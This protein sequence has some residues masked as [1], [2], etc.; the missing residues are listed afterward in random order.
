M[1]QVENEVGMLEDA[2]DWSPAANKMFEQPVPG[3]LL[4]YLSVHKNRLASG[5]Y[6]RWKDNDFKTAG[7]W[8]AVFGKGLATDEIF[9]AWH[10]ADYINDV[11]V[12]GK[13]EYPLPMFVNAALI[14]PNYKPGQYPSAGPLPHLID[15]WRAAAPAIDFLSPDIYFPNFSE[16]CQKYHRPGNPLFIPEAVLGPDAKAAVPALIC[17]ACGTPAGMA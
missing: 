14:R 16:W 1:V 13:A 8:E 5:L 15:I 17:T 7:T 9:M 11:A 12:A 10:Y 3:E 6:E 4:N 2:R